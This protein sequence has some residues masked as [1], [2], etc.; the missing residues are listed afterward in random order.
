MPK[1]AMDEF[2]KII[3]QSNKKKYVKEKIL[4]VHLGLGFEEVCHPCSRYRYE[5]SAV[6][7]LERFVKYCLAHTKKKD[8]TKDV[9]MEHPRLPEFP[10]LGTLTGDVDEYYSEQEKNTTN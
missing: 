3:A 2:E 5:Y 6:E 1:K 4:I 10:T 9:P 7:L 8:F